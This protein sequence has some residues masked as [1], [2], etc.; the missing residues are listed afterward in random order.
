LS[1]SANRK[2]PKSSI[3]CRH[4]QGKER[5]AQRNRVSFAKGVT[6]IGQISEGV[7][8]LDL[9]S[10]RLMANLRDNSRR[11]RRQTHKP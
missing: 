6:H 2:S 9:L 10:Q 1:V 7:E 5:K 3:A 8:D 11:L 4:C